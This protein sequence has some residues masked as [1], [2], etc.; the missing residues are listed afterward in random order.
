V[1]AACLLCRTVATTRGAAIWQEHQSWSLCQGRAASVA[2]ARLPGTVGGSV[3][4]RTGAAQASVQDAAGCKCTAIG[5][6]CAISAERSGCQPN[7]LQPITTCY[8]IYLLDW[9]CATAPVLGCV[10]GSTCLPT[11]TK[12]T[13]S[14]NS[15]KGVPAFRAA[16]G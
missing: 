4:R 10:T 15:Q 16:H 12:C 3:R 9:I 1:L 6:T 13:K 11:V 14:G 2:G 8:G 7:A 5:A